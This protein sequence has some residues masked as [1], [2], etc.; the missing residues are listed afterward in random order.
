[1]P[2]TKARD[3]MSGLERVGAQDTIET[4]ANRMAELH[5]DALPICGTDGNLHA[6]QG[7]IT[8]Q[9]ISERVIEEG[10]DPV[11]TR[12]GELPQKD[13][14]TIGADESIEDALPVMERHRI[15]RLPV[16][17]GHR[18]V[19]LVGVE[20]VAEALADGPGEPVL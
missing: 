11:A 12:V 8:E 4:A 7:M 16:V 5:V 2:M 6:M 3:I 17:E 14:G 19:G 20:D 1:M 18:V 10:R 9:D 15:G 13:T